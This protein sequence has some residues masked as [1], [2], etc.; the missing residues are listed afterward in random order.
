VVVRLE[1]SL[2]DAEG[3][4]VE[5]PG[6][7]ES[8]EFIFGTGQASPAIERAVDGLSVGA[9]T[10]VQ[11]QPR[12]AFGARDPAAELVLERSELPE[13]TQLGDELEA[14]GEDGETVFLRVVELDG[15]MARLDA[16]H[17]LAGQTVALELHVLETRIA[18]SAEL[19]A[20]EQ[21]LL[22]SSEENAPDVL[23]SRLLRGERFTP[24]ESG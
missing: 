8:I 13:T 18:T 14:E 12:E 6:P 2:Y 9:V 20:A 4:L 22:M 1:Y 11:L 10:R 16:N 15:E 19:R 23:A 24:P 17:P 3:A 5:A 7:E 21:A